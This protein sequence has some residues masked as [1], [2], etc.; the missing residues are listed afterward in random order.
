MGNSVLRL[1]A[2]DPRGANA[3]A[4]GV[5]EVPMTPSIP[6]EEMAR[7]REGARRR[8]ERRQRALA[9]RYDEAR[10]LSAEGAEILK[11]EFG[12]SRVAAFGSVVVPGRF[13]HRSDV[14]L[15]A[16]GIDE[17]LYLPAVARLLS[18]S[19]EISVDL[20]RAEEAPPALLAAA[21]EEGVTL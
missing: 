18:L 4:E 21:A 10:R 8:R 16:W 3:R 6:P 20:V 7:Y 15:I 11:R 14:D 17:K 12:A 5:T 9:T 2:H 13:H 19:R 1:D